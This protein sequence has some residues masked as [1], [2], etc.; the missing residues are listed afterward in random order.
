MNGERSQ[1]AIKESLLPEGEG[2]DEGEPRLISE[3][4]VMS[5]RR[6]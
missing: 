2:Q 6:P 4:R 5:V 3:R 1:S